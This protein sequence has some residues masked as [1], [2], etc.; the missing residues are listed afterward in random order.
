MQ[1]GL[2][3]AN[4]LEDF[5]KRIAHYEEVYVPLSEANDRELPFIK[6]IDTGDRFIVNRL[7]G[8]QINWLFEISLS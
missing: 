7:R 1:C 5:M 3:P 6:I 8:L 2:E 4:V